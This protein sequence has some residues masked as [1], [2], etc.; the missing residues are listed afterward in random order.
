DLR[1][2]RVIFYF[3]NGGHLAFE[4]MRLFGYADS[5]PDPDAYIREHG[6]GPDPLDPRFGRRDF[7]RLLRKRRGAIK[8]LLLAQNVIAGIG[9]LYADEILFRSSIHPRRSVERLSADEVKALFVNMRRLLSEVIAFKTGEKDYPAR[10]LLP[11][12]EE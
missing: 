4:D 10:F 3:E 2:A 7:R 11:H 8:P 9:N 6:L 5:P 12:R 1:F